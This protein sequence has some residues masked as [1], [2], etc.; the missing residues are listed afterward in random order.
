VLHREA[1]YRDALV[2]GD[3]TLDPKARSVLGAHQSVNLSG[4]EF[5][6]LARLALSPN[7]TVSRNELFRIIR[8]GATD[9]DRWLV[10]IHLTRLM[11]KLADVS[12]CRISRAPHDQGFMLSTCA[13]T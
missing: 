1:A 5:A 11:V 2:A 7:E 3:L 4:D 13:K 9:H 10:D 12:K 8:G 6:L